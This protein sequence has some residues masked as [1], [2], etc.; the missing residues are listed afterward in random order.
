MILLR[1]RTFPKIR[2]RIAPS[3]IHPVARRNG[4]L[5]SNYA[6]ALTRDSENAVNLPLGWRAAQCAIRHDSHE[7]HFSVENIAGGE[8]SLS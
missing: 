5:A 7:V 2:S 6:R 3:P 4:A 1:I 8:F